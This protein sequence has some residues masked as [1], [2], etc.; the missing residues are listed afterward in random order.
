MCARGEGSARRPR[1]PARPQLAAARAEPDALGMMRSRS[2]SD[3]QH[4][5]GRHV[6]ICY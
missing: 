5:A 1:L 3:R 4:P 6:L 2:R